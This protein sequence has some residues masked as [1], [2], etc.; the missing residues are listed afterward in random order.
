[1]AD[2]DQGAVGV[3]SAGAGTLAVATSEEKPARVGAPHLHHPPKE[4]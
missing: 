2:G 3:Q 4:M 1:M